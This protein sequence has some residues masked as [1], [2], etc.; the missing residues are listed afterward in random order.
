[1]N[2]P[3]SQDYNE[4]IQNP[5]S[6]F[7]DPG[8]KSGAV[9]INSLGL[10]VPRSGSFADVYQFKGGD[11]EMWAVKCFTRKVAGL[12]ERYARIDE[13]LT[14]A[15]LP[16]T[17]GFKYFE[18]GIRVHGQCYP[19]L[20]MEW[21]EGFTLNEFVR[22]NAD[23]PHYLHAL[24]QMWAK[25]T[26]RLRTNQL[27]H[28]DLQ[29]G[30]VLLVPGDAHNKLDMKLIDYDG[31]WVPA[32]ANIHSGEI[33]HPN[34]QH[35]RR[36]KERLYNADV[37]R[38][39]H[40]VIA[41][42]LRATLIG[43]RALWDRFDN[44]DNLLFKEA[45][46]RRPGE[47]ELFRTLWNLN[48]D[49]LRTLVGRLVLAIHDPLNRT[50]WLDDI[51][52][53]PGGARL[54]DDDK[55]KVVILLGDG[56]A[57]SGKKASAPSLEEF[58]DFEIVD[59]DDQEEE[60]SR[61]IGDRRTMEYFARPQYRRAKSKSKA[62]YVIGGMTLIVVLVLGI[63]ALTSAGKKNEPTRPEV[64][65]NKDQHDT[66]R[67]VTPSRKRDEVEGNLTEKEAWPRQE[68]PLEPV[69]PDPN[70][71]AETTEVPKQDPRVTGKL[72][73]PARGNP[74]FPQ[75]PKRIVPPRGTRPPL[76]P[77]E[78]SEP[79]RD[80]AEPLQPANKNELA[81]PAVL[82]TPLPADPKLRRIG[83]SVYLADMTEL[84]WIQGPP[85]WLLGKNG[86][87]GAITSN[88]FVVVDKNTPL[89][90]LSMAPPTLGFTRV[91]YSVGKRAKTF[92]GSAAISEHAPGINPEPVRFVILGDGKL[93][94]R[95]HSIKAHGVKED[96][97]LD[98]SAVS[99]LELRVY[100]ETKLN[101]GAFAVW[102]DPQLKVQADN[103]PLG[104]LHAFERPDPA[105]LELKPADEKL[106][107]AGEEVFLSDMSEFGSKKGLPG[108]TFA[109]DGTVGEQ[110]QPA[111]KIQIKRQVPKHAL[112][113]YPPVGDFTRVC[114]SVAKRAGIFNGAVAI[115]EDARK[116]TPQPVRFA[117]LGDGKL[118]W[119]SDAIKALQVVEFFSIDVSDVNVL[120]LR[121]Y[122]E[123]N[124]NAACPAVWIDPSVSVKGAE[125]LAK[126]ETEPKKSAEVKEIWNKKENVAVNTL[127]FSA[128]GKMVLATPATASEVRLFDIEV[129]DLAGSIDMKG[130]TIQAIAACA[131][132]M[133]VVND[134]LHKP[135][136][137]NIKT[138]TSVFDF[139]GAQSVTNQ[140]GCAQNGRVIIADRLGN[141]AVWNVPE[142]KLVNEYQIAL[143]APNRVQYVSSS[144]D[145]EWAVL[146]TT[147]N[148]V[149]S[150]TPTTAGFVPIGVTV[151]NAPIVV[152]PDGKTFLYAA[153][154]AV[155]SIFDTV[156]GR[157]LRALTGHLRTVKCYAFAKN[158]AN[159]LTMANDGTLRFWDAETAIQIQ[160]IRLS[161]QP[162]CLAVS[163]NGKFAATA[164]TKA[165]LLQ[166][167]QLPDRP[168]TPETRVKSRDSGVK[169]R[170]S[171]DR[172]Q[173]GP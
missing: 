20:K 131:D 150:M 113:M 118:L 7:S 15:Q 111:R 101:N 35:P 53:G 87:L 161:G 146:L 90:A 80:D 108:W 110:A 22:E 124:N 74:K 129:G 105:V 75:P 170:E 17:V 97:S 54:S 63:I 60:Q 121:V 25:L 14:K 172:K 10:P 30:N 144:A 93:L 103:K 40:L 61:P 142:T 127:A 99:I 58:S 173:N 133:I 151:R 3:T 160:E 72:I 50:P 47:S 159:V 158:G 115:S 145:G 32:L 9:T 70:P 96:F 52:L 78:K 136:V 36:L 46:L 140:L 48:D 153:S 102:V 49:V 128:D 164:T 137:W 23:N 85:G 43:G 65:R 71:Q 168:N 8:L 51:L 135:A 100:T 13:H 79:P 66:P 45:D 21:V 34:F 11:G 18:E 89:H 55:T 42:A 31:M 147:K 92:E 91:C 1:M 73:P 98:V 37:D 69:P 88:E 156:T 157:E 114:Y 106:A 33:G 28:A 166:L 86:A 126:K 6:C 139:K 56:R 169:N 64:V 82:L 163:P 19:L 132:D 141:I 39:P 167:W 148:E 27:A 83:E 119:R 152:S 59:D 24:L 130:T 38:Y 123:K 116:T 4:A 41:S 120:E 95:S 104:A 134:A 155:V 67:T 77:P 62:P 94:W 44:A 143:K 117:V 57:K 16:F 171:G 109:K 165:E 154:D 81:D 2:W 138:K 162:Q 149:Y 112:A 68:A 12:Q 122:V 29:H 76:Q 107:A 84:A 125:A 26:A 5:A